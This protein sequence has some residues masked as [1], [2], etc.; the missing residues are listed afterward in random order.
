MK[1]FNKLLCFMVVFVTVMAVFCTVSFAATVGQ[2]LTSPEAGWQRINDTNPNIVYVGHAYK[3]DYGSN[4]YDG[5]MHYSS[6]GS[7]Y[8]TFKFKGTKFRLISFANIDRSTT[9]YVSIDNGTIETFSAYSSAFG[10]S[11]SGNVLL[12]EKTGLSDSVHT[13]KVSYPAISTPSAGKYFSG[14]DA[15]D[16]DDTGYL[17]GYYAP[18]NLIAT[19]GNAKVDLSW[20]PVEGAASYIVK[21][22]LT[23]GGPY[24]I[25]TT[26]SAITYTDSNV[27]NGTT[28]YYVVSA[29]VNGIES[30]PSNEASATP[31]APKDPE[32]SG[33][34]AIL[35]ITMVT[36]EIKEYGLTA[37]ELQSFLT[38]YDGRS[39]GTDKAY[40]MIPK[41][42]NIKPFLSRKDYIAFDKISSFEVKEYTE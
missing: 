21:R 40:Y 2:K 32:P 23:T 28:Y 27:T 41:K 6:T 42:N 37:A 11:G 35:E 15:I 4:T 22:S 34:N 12:Y 8:Y 33:N 18:T 10:A 38:W 25:I 16:I 39:N 7:Q 29:E 17:V 20:D 19:G 26:T 24:E 14:L 3:N 30:D 36:G 9:N 5:D 13:V 31:T 1:R